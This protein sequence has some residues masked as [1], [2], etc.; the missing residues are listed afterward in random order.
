[1]EEALP[2]VGSSE[3]KTDGENVKETARRKTKVDKRQS[4]RSDLL[5]WDDDGDGGRRGS[6]LLQDKKHHWREEVPT[7]Q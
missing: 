4:T 7:L 2:K 6:S 3:V 5:E 1:L